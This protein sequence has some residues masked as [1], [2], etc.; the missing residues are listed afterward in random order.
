[1]GYIGFKLGLYSEFVKL[2]GFFGAFFI[3][4]RY[5][6]DLGDFLTRRTGLSIEWAA[7]LSMTL[8]AVALYLVLTRLARSMEKLV[9]VTFEERLNK[10]G[11]LIAGIARA[12]L[13]V[14]F[15]LVVMR[16]L[17]SDYLSA[18]IDQHSL[19]GPTL[20]KMAPAVY[21]AVFPTGIRLLTALRSRAS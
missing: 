16:Q 14:S 21:D 8:M 18:S 10:A 15:I 11:G 7:G 12:G 3:S 19:S 2:F 1:M 4:F 6:Q 17:P 20:S 5:Y 13:L 9:H